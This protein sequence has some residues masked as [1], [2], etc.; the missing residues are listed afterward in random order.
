MDAVVVGMSTK[1]YTDAHFQARERL[2]LQTH[3]STDTP[4][5]SA[6]KL[7]PEAKIP[8]KGSSY[9]AGFDLYASHSGCIAPRMRL[10]ISTGIA[11]AIP[12]GWYG[13]VAPRSGLAHNF[14]IDVLAGVVDSDYRGE[15]KV[16][17]MNHG[18]GDF[19]FEAGDRIAQL[20]PEF[21]GVWQIQEAAS[22]DDTIRGVGGFGST[23]K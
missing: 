12:K 2:N 6:V 23:G 19:K 17:L 14:G 10:A 15:V 3:G 5:F 18:S 21:C 22:L 4:F 7:V 11:V 13:R 1:I 9:A 16:I 8:T 20:V